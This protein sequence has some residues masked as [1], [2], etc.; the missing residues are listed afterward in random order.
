M[1]KQSDAA[2]MASS[3]ATIKECEDIGARKERARI[4]AILKSPEAASNPE[5]AFALAMTTDMTVE[6]ARTAARR[7]ATRR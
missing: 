1:S 5:R 7:P 6:Q 4:S 3:L 2:T